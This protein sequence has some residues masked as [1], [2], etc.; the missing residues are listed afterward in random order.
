MSYGI[1]LA[2]NASATTS[3]QDFQGGSCVC[4]FCGT[5]G[6][7]TI[8][9]QML[10]Q[11]GTTYI[12]VLSLTSAGVTSLTLPPGRFRVYVNGGT[13]SGLYVTIMRVV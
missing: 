10:G 13:P 5:I 9:L 1:N 2:S 8:K 11:D 3:A 4:V 6:G 12:D 7:A